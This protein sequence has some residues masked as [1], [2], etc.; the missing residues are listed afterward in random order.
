[1]GIFTPDVNNLRELYVTMLE[2]ALSSEKQIVNKGL[3]AMIEKSTA[4]EL[5]EAFRTHL[6]ESKEHVSRGEG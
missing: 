5:A 4:P 3:P 6:E 1:M 2:R